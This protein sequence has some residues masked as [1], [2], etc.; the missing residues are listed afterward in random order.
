[1]STSKAKNVAAVT[2]STVAV[3]TQHPLILALIAG[4]SGLAVQ[5]VVDLK[6]PIDDV[7]ALIGTLSPLKK[8]LKAFY[9]EA[10]DEADRLKA[11]QTAKNAEVAAGIISAAKNEMLE[12]LLAAGVTPEDAA[13]L[14]EGKGLAGTKTRK[15]RSTTT[16]VVDGKEYVIN[17]RMSNEV[18]ALIAASGLTN[19]E[20]I[21]QHLKADTAES[22]EESTSDAE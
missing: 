21:K 10:K 13:A 16:L 3:V 12:K 1:M 4:D 19:E 11:E 9:K 22:T 18:K 2:S 5:A 8:D 6:L 15:P 7:E 20:F 14:L 17:G